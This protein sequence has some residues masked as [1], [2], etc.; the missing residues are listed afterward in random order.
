MH[1]ISALLLVSSAKG[2]VGKSTTAYNLAVALSLDGLKVGLLDG[3]IYGPS[4]P[5]LTGTQDNSPASDGEKFTPLL[6]Q[7]LQVISMGHL[8]EDD[9]PVVWRGP[10]VQRAIMQLVTD[11]DWGPLDF[12]VVDMPP[13]TGDIALSMGQKAKTLADKAA[14]IVVTTPQQLAVADARKGL[15]AFRKLDLPILGVVENMSAFICPHC[16]EKTDIFG[17]KG[18]AALAQATDLPLL[19]QFPLDMRVQQGSEVGKSVLTQFPDSEVAEGFRALG[20]AIQAGFTKITAPVP[21]AEAT[22]PVKVNIQ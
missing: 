12:L 14:A 8:V 19:A 11:V 15:E 18:G 16:G 2:G 21:A 20:Q 5:R 9:A 7:G 22:G 17:S 1:K 10:L 4:I 6:V 13:G 3:D